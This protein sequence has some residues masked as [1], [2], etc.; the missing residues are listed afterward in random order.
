MPFCCYSILWL[1]KSVKS[2]RAKLTFVRMHE[3]M[4][5]SSPPQKEQTAA[6]KEGE[7]VE[8][9]RVLE[10]LTCSL[11]HGASV[12]KISWGCL[13]EENEYLSKPECPGLSACS[14]L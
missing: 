7:E 1:E 6:G 14:F 10:M 13:C 5:A 9:E 12:R 4:A 2:K 11:R 8:R 3:Q